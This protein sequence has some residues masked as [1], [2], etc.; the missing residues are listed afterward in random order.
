MATRNTLS[1]SAQR[2]PPS[3]PRM[4]YG[5]KALTTLNSRV[6]LVKECHQ[7]GDEFWTLPGGGV[8]SNESFKAGLHR[9]LLEELCCEA[10]ITD[11]VTTYWYS[12]Q[13]AA[14]LVSLYTVFD[15]KLCS[16]V[17][18][19]E[20]EGILE[21]NWFKPGNLP[22]QTIPQIRHLILNSFY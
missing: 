11:V 19:V 12:H 16:Q 4:R 14:N 7:N 18:P 9:E 20:R 2:T 13:S 8:K 6:F 15:C 17:Q 10:K 5:V 3:T 1:L 22:P 21:T